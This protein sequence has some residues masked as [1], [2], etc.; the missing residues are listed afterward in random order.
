[1]IGPG[2]ALQLWALV[3]LAASV[4]ALPSELLGQL[5]Y[6]HAVAVS[7]IVALAI[8]QVAAAQVGAARRDR[9]PVRR[10]EGFDYV[11][12]AHARLLGAAALLLAVPLMVLLVRGVWVPHCDLR[13]GMLWY[14]LLPGV[15]SVYVTSASLFVSLATGRALTAVLVTYGFFVATL[16]VAV[17]HLVTEPPLFAF[18]S[19]V[20]YIPG[21]IYDER[22]RIVPALLWGRGGTLLWAL[23]FLLATMAA[24]DPKRHR[25]DPVQLLQLDYTFE[26][27]TPRIGLLLSVVGL[28]VLHGI[29]TTNGTAP[30]AASI[31]RTLGGRLVTEN[32]RIY[33]DRDA[34]D[35]AEARLLAEEHELR[36]RQIL[37]SLGWDEL[38]APERPLESYVYPSPDV[39]KRLMGARHTSFAD[40]FDR[41]MHLNHRP[42]PHPVLKHEL[43]HL[44][45]ASFAGWLGFNPRIGWHEGFA[46]AVDWEE[47]RLT[48]DQWTKAMRTEELLPD[49]HAATSARGFWT[50]PASRAYL[51]MGSLSRYLLDAHGPDAFVGFFGDAD[52]EEHFG[53]SLDDILTAWHAHLDTV[54]VSAADLSYARVRLQRGAIFD[55]RCAREAAEISDRAWSDLARGY[56]ADA[57]ERFDV[58]AGWAPDDPSPQLGRLRALTGLGRLDDARAL[59]RT[60]ATRDDIGARLVD[61]AR[62]ALGDLAWRADDLDRARGHFE[63]LAVTGAEPSLVRGAHLKLRVLRD[64]LYRRVFVDDPVGAEATALLARL[65]LTGPDPGIAHYLLGRRLHGAGAWSTAAEHFLAATSG[66]LVDPVVSMECRR[67]LGETLYRQG[68]LDDAVRVFEELALDARYP[69]ERIRITS[70]LERCV[71][72]R[73]NPVVEIERTP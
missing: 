4:L 69:A 20:G 21:P 7:V 48:P 52:A 33:Y 10:R 67:L 15:T 70:W 30:T 47:D 62:N 13:E 12:A 16:L 39:K 63:E 58:L 54:V 53:R 18:T 27:L 32:F 61:T 72:K 68:N 55:R 14:L 38:P 37:D 60:L 45:S 17:H 71:W 44:V 42:F 49:M 5:G 24:C 64:P 36:L 57:L 46:V 11:L 6:D 34:L 23:A 2:R 35:D 40:P 8:P 22:I 26:N 28:V 73:T 19:V 51:S 29:G 59:A 31:Q 66:D 9:T 25:V 41:A 1:V 3:L 56:P 50:Q 65:S 43:A